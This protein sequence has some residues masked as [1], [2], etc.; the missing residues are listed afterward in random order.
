MK[1][2]VSENNKG[3]DAVLT[4]FKPM[5]QFYIPVKTSENHRFSYAFR[6]YRNGILA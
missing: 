3:N 1:V 6:G 2:I 4:N 5:F